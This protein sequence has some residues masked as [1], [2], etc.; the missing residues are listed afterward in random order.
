LAARTEPLDLVV[1]DLGLP[2][3][4]GVDLLRQICAIRPTPAIALTGFGMDSDIQRCLEAGFAEH[5]TKPINVK[6]LEAA[7]DRVVRV[8]S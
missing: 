4:S 2:D 3:G 7:I 8:A 5:L 6:A 1:S